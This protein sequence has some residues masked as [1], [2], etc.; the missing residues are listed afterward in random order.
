MMDVVVVSQAGNYRNSL[1]AL[2]KSAPNVGQ[3]FVMDGINSL[4]EIPLKSAPGFVVM[5]SAA[6]NGELGFWLDLVQA[7]WP[8]ARRVLLTDRIETVGKPGMDGVGEVMSKSI[9]A[10][11][12]YRL[13]RQ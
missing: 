1:V 5:D 10:G 3:V 12:F 4:E 2:V 9:S 8:L 13:F 6:A 7:R 11:E